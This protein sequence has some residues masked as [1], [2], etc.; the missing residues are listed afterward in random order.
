LKGRRAFLSQG[1]RPGP[2]SIGPPGLERADLNREVCARR[3]FSRGICSRLGRTE[4]QPAG[5]RKAATPENG[6]W[7]TS[8]WRRRGRRYGRRTA[9]AQRMPRRQKRGQEGLQDG[10]H[11]PPLQKKPQL[12]KAGVALQVRGD[13][14][15]AAATG[16]TTGTS[17]LQKR[18]RLQ[19]AGVALLVTTKKPRQ[20]RQNMAHGV[21]RGLK[22]HPLPLPPPPLG[23]GRGIE[24]EGGVAIPGLTP[25]ATFYRPSGPG[26]R[27][28]EPRGLRPA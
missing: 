6:S 13:G 24:G 18:P 19:K 1:S 17:P 15:D 20:G 21:S 2:H 22:A 27:R 23:R 11:R 8:A 4:S 7:A 26:A 10:G 12:Q 25:W 16:T 3:K 14:G 28:S 5:H 9:E